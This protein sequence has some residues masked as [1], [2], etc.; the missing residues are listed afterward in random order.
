MKYTASVKNKTEM[1]ITYSFL[2]R[3][4][5]EKKIL[6]FPNLHW[7]INVHLFSWFFFTYHSI[8]EIKIFW[9][10]IFIKNIYWSTITKTIWIKFIIY[11]LHF[12]WIVNLFV[13]V[14]DEII[15]KQRNKKKSQLQK[16][17]MDLKGLIITQDLSSKFYILSFNF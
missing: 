9:C 12:I 11:Y 16:K 6:I 13:N 15:A 3:M 14:I 10:P 4:L 5:I 7:D 8:N 17:S 2:Y 1:L